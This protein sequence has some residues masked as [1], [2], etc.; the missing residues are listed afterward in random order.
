[1]A[2]DDDLSERV[3]ELMGDVTSVSEQRMFGGLAFLVQGN[4]A[5]AAS[6]RGILVRVSPAESVELVASTA[7]EVAVMGTRTMRGW[8]RVAPKELQTE[9]E[10]A[11]WVQRGV[12]FALSLPAKRPGH[13]SR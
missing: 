2:Y 1:M 8:V 9:R 3:R 11:P 7:A 5:I 6:D 10:L 4:L 12:D 13:S